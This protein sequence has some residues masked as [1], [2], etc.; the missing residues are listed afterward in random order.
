MTQRALPSTVEFL[1]YVQLLH[2]SQP[3]PSAPHN[4]K[5]GLSKE[6]G[7]FLDIGDKACNIAAYMLFPMIHSQLHLCSN[8]QFLSLLPLLA[9]SKGP[10]EVMPAFAVP[11]IM[12]SPFHDS[13]ESQSLSYYLFRKTLGSQVFWF[14]R[15]EGLQD[16]PADFWNV[17]ADKIPLIQR[18]IN[19][20]AY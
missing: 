5:A 12:P 1:T 9:P 17:G 16:I 18:L 4:N 2:L 6:S 11:S 13:Q 15:M 14:L 19:F 3:I 20:P 8:H 10:A 7:C